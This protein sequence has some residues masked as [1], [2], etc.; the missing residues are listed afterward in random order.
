M[1]LLRWS[2]VVV[3]GLTLTGL[4]TRARGAELPGHYFK[5]MRAELEALDK[6]KANPG[7]M[8]AAAVLYARKH[9]ANPSFGDREKLELALHLG[10]LLAGEAEKDKAENKQHYEW[11]IHFW[12]DTYRLLEKDLGGDRKARWKRELEKITRWFADEVDARIDFPRYQGPYIRT[13]TNHLAIFASTVHLAGRALPNKDWESLG[14]RGLHRL[15]VEEQTDDG[16]WG[17]FTDNGPATGYNYLTMNCVAL[18]FEHSQDKA[19]LEALRRATTFHKFFTWPDGTPVE[20]INGRNRHWGVS[21]WGHFGFSHWPD[22]RGYAEFLAQFFAPSP[23]TPLPEGEGRKALGSKSIGRIAQS[24]LYY[25]EGPT[26]KT[27]QQFP[28]FSH[29]MKVPAGIR[30]TGPWTICLSGL[31]DTPIDSQFTL[32]RQGHLSI[33]HEKHGLIVTGANSRNQPELA[34]FLEK[35]KDRVTT[36]PLSSRLRMSEDRDRLALGY[37]TFFAEAEAPKPADDRMTFRFAIT[38]TGRGRLQDVQ[39]NLQLCLKTGD[40]LETAKAKLVLGEK[41]VE[42]GPDQI[43]GWIRHRGWKLTVDPTA[44]LVWPILPFNPYKNGPE[45]DMRHAV[46]VLTVPV[47]VDPLK[48]GALNWRRGEIAFV[49]ESEGAKPKEPVRKTDV[50]IQGE[51]FHINGQPTYQGRMWKDRRIEGLLF[52]SRMVQAIFNDLNPETVKLWAYPDTKKWDSERNTREFIAAMST[53]RKHGLLGITLNLQGGSPQGYSQKQPWHNSAFKEDGSLRADYMSR[54]ER[55]LDRA[56]ELGMVV[57]LGFFYFGQDE[58]LKDEDAITRGVDNAIDWLF[59]KGYRNVLIEV[60]NEC[61][62]RYDHD[63]L[64]PQRVHELIERVKKRTKDGRRFLVAT[65]YGGGVIPKEN[66][67][68]ASDFLL[69]HGN[70]VKDPARIAEMVQQ[71]RKVPGYRPMPILFNE[72]DHFDFDQPKNNFVAAIGEYASWGYFDFRMKGEG[73]DDGY[74]SVPV[75]WSAMSPRKQGFFRLLSEITGEGRGARDKGRVFPGNTWATKTPQ[76]AS[77]DVEKLDAFRDF[78]GGRGAIV[79]GGHL[80]YS[81]GDITK[82][83]DIAST[84]KPWLVH[85]LLLLLEQGI[86]KSLDDPVVTWEPHLNNLNAGLGFKDR[87]I[88][89]RHLA[90]QT[91][92]YGVQEAPGEAFDYSDYNMALFFDTLLLKVYKSDY[93]KIDTEVLNGKLTDLL[94]CQ[95]NP[96]FLAMF[97]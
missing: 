88:T 24:A 10:D 16:Y 58:R 23:P 50:T 8:F 42:L 44:R 90:C 22:G 9:P 13:S 27:P 21:P 7:A 32:D 1:N 45:T 20:T 96:T 97:S 39:L 86:I 62:V 15:A 19:A 69:L 12:L 87:K 60:N 65:S 40:T 76:Q 56:D 48:D 11:E 36:I 33:Y 43:G 38:E 71:T 18:Y 49:L 63:I 66:V 34:T 6:G 5:L 14:A 41:R 28:E 51:S 89:W 75:N 17:E 81:W 92:C 25:H 30:K 77:L 64:K 31:I 59:A 72:D 26:E 68:R 37:R 47:K 94:Q 29:Q 79:R 61:N 52:N 80:I 54:L 73:F 3:A 78:V 2:C 84:F 74:Q 55:V 46:G 83:A 4:P 67:V 85:L 35:T 57:I 95:D 53:W 91:S 93:A 82:R 70:G